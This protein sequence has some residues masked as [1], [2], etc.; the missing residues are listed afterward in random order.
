[1]SG[2]GGGIDRPAAGWWWPVPNEE[3]APGQVVSF[4]V[5]PEGGGGQNNN[6]SS[7]SLARDGSAGGDSPQERPSTRSSRLNNSAAVQTISVAT[8]AVSVFRTVI[9]PAVDVLAV[10]AWPLCSSSSSPSQLHET[11]E[12]AT[13][14]RA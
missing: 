11:T 2:G 14:V 5:R 7:E 13:T 9:F 10:I 1:M 4:V 3:D 6:N 8:Q 12:I